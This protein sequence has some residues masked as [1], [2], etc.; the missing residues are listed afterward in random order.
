MRVCASFSSLDK[1]CIFMP[2][3]RG[4]SA[5]YSCAFDD[6]LV[7]LA[8][9]LWVIG[10]CMYLYEWDAACRCRGGTALHSRWPARLA[11]VRDALEPRMQLN[12]HDLP[13]HQLLHKYFP[14]GAAQVDKGL[15][16]TKP[17]IEWSKNSWN[18]YSIFLKHIF[19]LNYE[20]K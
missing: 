10:L 20:A 11:V 8:E 12:T 18:T 2:T 15:L 4:K 1:N 14:A 3:C 17:S 9:S 13:T 6:T 19:A 16:K 7:H 5:W